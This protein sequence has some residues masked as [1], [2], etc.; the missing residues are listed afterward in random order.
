[1]KDSPY[2]SRKLFIFFIQTVLLV[3]IV[4]GLERFLIQRGIALWARDILFTILLFLLWLGRKWPPMLTVALILFIW[5]ITARMPIPYFIACRVLGVIFSFI[6]GL[7]SWTRGITATQVTPPKKRRVRPI[8][9]LFALAIVGAVVWSQIGPIEYIINPQKQKSYLLAK[10]VTPAPPLSQDLLARRLKEHVD[11]LAARIGKRAVYKRSAL[12][13][14]K[15]YVR[16]HF[17]SQG[18]P[19][20]LLSYKLTGYAE[21]LGEVQNIE[22]VLSS[23]QGNSKPVWIIGAHYD[24]ALGTPGADDNASAVAVLMELAPL[25]KDKNLSADIRLVAFVAEEP[26]YFGTQDMGSYHYAQSLKLEG[27]PVAG[28]ISLEMLGYFSDQPGSQLYPPFLA[29]WYPDQ[30]SFVALV[31][32]FSSRRL[33]RSFKKEWN[34]NPSFPLE[35]IILPGLLST[36]ALS[37]QLSFWDQGFPAVMLSD[38]AFLRNPH[39]HDATDC[40]ETLDFGKMSQVTQSLV[41]TLLQILAR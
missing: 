19:T 9:I 34:S 4:F 27:V 5:L 26:P 16:N 12:A 40:V 1:M 41:R 10:A 3:L 30:G 38:T 6:M 13:D 14:A 29:R 32:N 7:I 28:M 36:M 31:G 17:V 11:T 8:R 2:F 24:T 25:L 15:N 21:R 23:P 37:D 20:R 18:L 39:Y 33:V 35:T 22:A